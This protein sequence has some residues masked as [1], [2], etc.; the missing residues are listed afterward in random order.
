MNSLPK[1]NKL[2]LRRLHQWIWPRSLR[3]QLLSRS[4][5]VLAGLLLLIGILQF[6]I[7][8]SFL[9]RNQAKPCKN[10]SCPCP[11][12]GLESSHVVA[13]P[14]ILLEDRQVTDLAIGCYL[15]RTGHWRCLI[16]K[17]HL[18]MFWG[19]RSESSSSIKR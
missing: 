6:W 18:R 14:T 3:S 2:R 7:M 9:Y 12:F 13:L 8:E 15:F 10:S 19:R 16:I 1:K 5:F 11:R 4:L 17:V